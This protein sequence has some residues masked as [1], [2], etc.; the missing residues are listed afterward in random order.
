ME[1]ARVALVHD[2]LTGMR[3]GERVLEELCRMFPKADL[4]TLLHEPGS[5]TPLLEE[6]TIVASPLNRAWI[7]QRYRH[8]LP[9]FPWAVSQLEARGYDLLISTHHAVAKA[10]PHDLE[11]PHLCY[12]FTPMRY[13]WDQADAYLGHGLRRFLSAPLV[14]YLRR[15]D[16]KTS[17]P[18]QVTRFVGISRVIVERIRNRYARDAGLVYPPVEVDRF[19]IGGGS[20]DFYLLVGGFVPYKREDVA[21]EAFRG[22]PQRLVVAGDGPSRRRLEA[23]APPNVRFLGRVSDAQ[24]AELFSGCRALIYP[25]EEDFG[26]IPVEAQASG[27]PVIAFARGGAT[28]TVVAGDDRG[29]EPTGV[30]F[31]QQTPEA[32]REAILAFESDIDHFSPDAIRRHALHFGPD[33]FRRGFRAELEALQR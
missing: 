16:Q 2:W 33:T 29:S 18:E 21:I 20:R 19:S 26:I 5:T 11:T 13:V 27:R 4:F 31:E 3:G 14:H 6:R 7:R 25:Q 12:C 9:L 17:G 8:F 24:L 32:L 30:F 28:E 1:G 15:F 23:D 10:L 22:L